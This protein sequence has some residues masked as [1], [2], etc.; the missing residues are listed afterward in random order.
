MRI[1]RSTTVKAGACAFVE[2][3]LVTGYKR[4]FRKEALDH[5]ATAEKNTSAE[6][7]LVTAPTCFRLG[8]GGGA[9]GGGGAEG[10]SVEA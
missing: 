1:R 4:G 8:D 5:A 6:I 10:Y 9:G 7:K 3:Y 2:F